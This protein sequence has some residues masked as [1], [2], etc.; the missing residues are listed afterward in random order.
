MRNRCSH[1]AGTQLSL[2]NSVQEGK[3]KLAARP[4]GRAALPNSALDVVGKNVVQL[5][6][7]YL[8]LTAF[9][10][11]APGQCLAKRALAATSF[12]R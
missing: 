7:Q 6:L 5:L 2:G 1:V 11:A 12:G 3:V 8:R 9:L 10:E 4:D